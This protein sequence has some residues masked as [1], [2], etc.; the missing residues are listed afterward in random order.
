MNW[1]TQ[2][3]VCA[4][5]IWMILM[6]VRSACKTALINLPSSEI[7]T[8]TLLRIEYGCFVVLNVRKMSPEKRQKCLYWFGP[9]FLFACIATYFFIT[10]F[11]FALIY[12]V[13]D[14]ETTWWRSLISSG[15][16]LSTL[17]FSTP[18]TSMGQFL[19]ILEGGVGLGIIVF[20]LT[21]IPGY[22]SIVQ[23]REEMSAHLYARTH[24]S[25]DC[26]AFYEWA[27]TAGLKDSLG[28]VWN[29]WEDFL[30]SIGDTHSESLILV[31]T[32]SSHLGQSWVVSVFTMLDAANLAATTLK[33][34]GRIEAEICLTEGIKSLEMT[35]ELLQMHHGPAPSECLQKD[36]Y[37][38]LCQR[39]AAKG[40]E[41]EEDGE[42]SW[43]E[44]RDNRSRYEHILVSLSSTLFVDLK[45]SLLRFREGGGDT[46]NAIR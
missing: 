41:L 44:F 39:L 31:F 3:L 19:A 4:L 35:A 8:R 23:Q 21:F 11:G 22:Q 40:Y 9:V 12:W 14:S 24:S 2:T 10:M 17:G 7:V 26:G 37:D 45:P 33:G 5:G 27:A 42:K 36:C 15:S 43:I 34:Q 28:E 20:L 13:T 38:A 30:R 29:K 6:V 46:G 1:I 18:P 16:A 25:P 32:P